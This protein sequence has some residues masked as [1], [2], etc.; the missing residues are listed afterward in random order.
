M[1]AVDHFLH[2]IF[3][4]PKQIRQLQTLI[5]SSNKLDEKV[6]QQMLSIVLKGMGGVLAFTSLVGAVKSCP[7]AGK[8][9]G[10]LA[11]ISS[12]A[13]TIF[14]IDCVMIGTNL[15]DEPHG[16]LAKIKLLFLRIFRDKIPI[17]ETGIRRLCKYTIITGHIA[18]ALYRE[19][20]S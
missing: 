4:I 19:S 3:S 20:E 13:F 5:E 6:A 7:K 10:S 11:L 17:D 12:I 9:F 16:N 8:F 14:G 1:V 15:G 18:I 2:G